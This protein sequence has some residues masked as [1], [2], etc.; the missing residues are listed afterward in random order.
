FF[1]KYVDSSSDSVP[2]GAEYWLGQYPGWVKQS[3]HSYLYTEPF[4][5]VVH[6]TFGIDQPKTLV[7]F[8]IRK[9]EDSIQIIR[10]F[11]AEII[12]GSHGFG[13]PD[14]VASIPY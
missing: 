11:F 1:K 8:I 6:G 3:Q 14:H 13:H 2:I 5:P 9:I 10:D 7:M 4:E 12:V